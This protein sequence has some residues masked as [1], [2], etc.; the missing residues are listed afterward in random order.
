M[1]LVEGRGKPIRCLRKAAR[2]APIRAKDVRNR[3]PARIF[4]VDNPYNERTI[5]NGQV[6]QLSHNQT[7]CRLRLGTNETCEEKL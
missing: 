2:E 1:C 4:T 5:Q 6:S 3:L 7:Q